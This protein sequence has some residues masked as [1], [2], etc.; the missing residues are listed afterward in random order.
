MWCETFREKEDCMIFSALLVL[1]R[2]GRNLKWSESQQNHYS[3]Q[4]PTLVMEGLLQLHTSPASFL[5]GKQSVA[6]WETFS[7]LV[8]QS[9]TNR[10]SAMDWATWPVFF[11]SL[12]SLK[13]SRKQIRMRSCFS[14]PLASGGPNSGCH[15]SLCGVWRFA[16]A[17]RTQN[18]RSE[19][20]CGWMQVL[21]A[22]PFH[23][24]LPL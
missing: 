22:V 9:S 15:V 6:P 24:R 4:K 8:A 18:S 3:S 14:S 16:G 5:L 23:S 17:L 2:L 19:A 20:G 12:H 7:S 11:W 21:F 13:D 1:E 10:R